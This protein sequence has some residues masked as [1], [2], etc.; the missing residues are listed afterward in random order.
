M[1]K[2]EKE[3]L[4]LHDQ[5]GEM[6]YRQFWTIAT[7][8]S[9]VQRFKNHNTCTHCGHQWESDDEEK[10]CPMCGFTAVQH[11]SNRRKRINVDNV[12]FTLLVQAFKG[13]QVLRLFAVSNFGRWFNGTYET[14]VYV[15][16]VR[17]QWLGADG[18]NCMLS[19][20]LSMH[21]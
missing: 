13:W 19:K 15:D 11:K 16:E 5:L 18:E 12:R 9:V 7:Q 10:R 4:K 3:V 2:I 8:T 20:R 17:Q 6:T 14:S 21:P 1:N